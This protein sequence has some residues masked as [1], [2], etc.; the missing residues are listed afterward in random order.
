MIGRNGNC[1]SKQCGWYR[2]RDDMTGPNALF[3]GTHTIPRG[4]ARGDWPEDADHAAEPTRR[5]QPASVSAQQA[6]KR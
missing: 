3:N 4:A 6:G 5:S 2:Y 1:A